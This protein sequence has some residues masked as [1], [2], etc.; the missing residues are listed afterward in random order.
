MRSGIK[1]LARTCPDG[2][3]NYYVMGMRPRLQPEAVSCIDVKYEAVCEGSGSG[4]RGVA[5]NFLGAA[6]D[7]F[8]GDAVK[9]APTP[10]CE[11]RL[12]RVVVRDVTE[13]G[14]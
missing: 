2:Q 7:C 10:A 13:C 1:L 11:V 6:T 14:D 12:V 5:R 8:M 4:S 3:G 9:I